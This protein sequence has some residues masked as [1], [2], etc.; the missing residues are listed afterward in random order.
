MIWS[1]A[2]VTAEQVESPTVHGAEMTDYPPRLGPGRTWA[3][4]V[5][6]QTMKKLPGKAVLGL[7]EPLDQWMA[8]AGQAE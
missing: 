3:E 1:W 7:P 4:C 6:P 8:E 5:P 2:E